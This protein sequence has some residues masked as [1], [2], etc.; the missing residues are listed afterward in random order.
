MSGDVNADGK[1][2]LIVCR[3]GSGSS[4]VLSVFLG[5]GNGSFLP[6]TDTP[7]GGQVSAIQVADFNRDG[8]MDIALVVNA[9]DIWVLLGKSDGTLQLPL[10]TK[11]SGPPG[12]A[13]FVADLN[14]DGIPDVLY[15]SYLYFGVGDGLSELRYRF[16]WSPL[17]LSTLTAMA[18]RIWSVSQAP[19]PAM[20]FQYFSGQVTAYLTLDTQYRQ[21]FPLN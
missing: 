3:P 10:D 1:S 6:S 13:L 7:V 11:V 17:S 5:T 14:R 9:T 12:S 18:T 20:C 19:R 2:D 4:Y 8:K 15:G 16:R 21:T